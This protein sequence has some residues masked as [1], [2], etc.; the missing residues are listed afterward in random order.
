MSSHHLLGQPNKTMKSIQLDG[1]RIRNYSW[2]E[3]LP[4][5]SIHYCDVI[6]FERSSNKENRCC[7]LCGE[8]EDEKHGCLI[9]KQNKGVCRSCDSTYWLQQELGVVIKFCK[10]CKLFF[11]LIEFDGKPNTTKCGTC[12]KRG[13]DNYHGKM[14]KKRHAQTQISYYSSRESNTIVE[15]D[16]T[17]N[18]FHTSQKIR[19]VSTVNN[20]S[21]FPSELGSVF[22]PLSL[23]EDTAVATLL[24]MDRIRS[25]CRDF[26]AFHMDSDEGS[27]FSP[28]SISERSSFLYASDI[29]N[30]VGDVLAQC[31]YPVD[32]E[33]AASLLLATAG[34]MGRHYNETIS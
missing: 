33:A 20:R 17:N 13:R 32:D 28:T 19:K 30:Q 11:S 8:K 10:G 12:R 26:E 4:P 7:V 34:V 22:T 5:N 14:E 24:G 15:D 25:K 21:S 31:N 29:E 3:R 27:S 23:A 16:E 2:G 9:P 1:H 18:G 6:N